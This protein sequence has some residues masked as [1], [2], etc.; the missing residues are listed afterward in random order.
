MYEMFSE[1]LVRKAAN[2]DEDDEIVGVIFP[3]FDKRYIAEKEKL[4]DYTMYV[5]AKEFNG[6]CEH[7]WVKQ[8][9]ICGEQG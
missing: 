9:S 3:M 8:C 1:K 7:Q 5:F 4:I 6:Q 2:L